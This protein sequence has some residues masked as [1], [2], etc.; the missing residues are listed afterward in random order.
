LRSWTKFE[1]RENNGNNG[2]QQW[3]TMAKK[4]GHGP[5]LCGGAK[6]KDLDARMRGH[7]VRQEELAP[8]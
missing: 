7:D 2:K 5:A 4:A 8:S 1:W 3:E 6:Q